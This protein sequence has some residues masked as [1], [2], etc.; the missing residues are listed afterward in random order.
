MHPSTQ[1]K[2]GLMSK[3]THR[4]ALVLSDSLCAAQLCGAAVQSLQ[5][6]VLASSCWGGVDRGR[7]GETGEGR[8]GRAAGGE[9][10][11]VLGALWQLRSW[12]AHAACLRALP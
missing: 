4:P 9:K 2:K 10:L 8:A 3:Q 12:P 6:Q 7:K 5:V 1:A 11:A